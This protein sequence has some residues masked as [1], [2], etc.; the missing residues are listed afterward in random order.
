MDR[1]D[2]S[3][4]EKEGK[5]N[6]QITVNDPQ[7]YWVVDDAR[8]QRAPIVALRANASSVPS[9]ADQDIGDK[10]ANDISREIFIFAKIDG[11]VRVQ[12]ECRHRH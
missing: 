11:N 5:R 12:R 9:D 4:A 6:G 2:I 10:T 8:P 1:S 7:A 3:I